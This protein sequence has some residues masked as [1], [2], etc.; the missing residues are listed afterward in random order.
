MKTLIGILIIGV[1]ITSTLYAGPTI[2][3]EGLFGEFVQY[4]AYQFVDFIENGD[5]SYARN[6]YISAESLY[7]KA[8]EFAASRKNYK[9]LTIS[10]LSLGTALGKQGKTEQALVTFNQ[11]L[12]NKI[13]IEN[14]N[15][16]SI[17][18]FNL[19][20]AY[21]T[22]NYFDSAIIN[23]STAIGIVPSEYSFYMN[24]ADAYQGKKKYDFAILDYSRTIEL[25]SSYTNAYNNRGLCYYFKRN[26]FDALK[27]YNKAVEL[28]SGYVSVY[29]NRGLLYEAEKEYDLAI[30]D[31]N[32]AIKLDTAY[33][34]VMVELGNVYLTKNDKISALHWYEQ[35]LKYHEHL[36]N[37]TETDVQ[38][39]INKLGQ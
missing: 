5:F 14:P 6:D 22:L 39:K 24:R 19:G 25:E 9:L 1:L 7:Q 13:S 33:A 16:L 4:S 10:L 21:H 3:Y 11:C 36:N 12:N 23:Y 8:C 15:L 37:Y 17:L 20:V 27:D 30:Q 32:Q 31:Y 38:D 28:D 26:Y 35:A 29:R 18:Y 34:E 2:S